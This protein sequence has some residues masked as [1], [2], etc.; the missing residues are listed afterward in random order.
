MWVETEFNT[1][2]QNNNYDLFKNVLNTQRVSII[3]IQTI[4]NT[5]G[6]RV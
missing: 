2:L 6:R 3:S 1:K 4:R 5:G